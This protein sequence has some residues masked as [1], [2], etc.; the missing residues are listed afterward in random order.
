MDWSGEDLMRP[1]PGCVDLR[2]G[3]WE[4]LPQDRT[5]HRILMTMVSEHIMDLDGAFAAA[6]R[7]LAPD[8]SLHFLHHNYTAWNG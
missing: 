2:T 1:F 8:G 7:W 5:Y 4:I 3:G 6:S